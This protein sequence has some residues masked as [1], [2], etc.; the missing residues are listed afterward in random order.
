MTNMVEEQKVEARRVHAHWEGRPFSRWGGILAAFLGGLTFLTAVAV[1]LLGV[2][3]WSLFWSVVIWF[4]WPLVFSPEMTT[5]VFS[6]PTPAYWKILLI[7]AIGQF[8]VK[9]SHRAHDSNH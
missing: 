2:F 4:F 6:T 7:V 1:G 8:I 3:A 9:T 5:W